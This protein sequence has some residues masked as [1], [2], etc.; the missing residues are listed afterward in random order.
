MKNTAFTAKYYFYYGYCFTGNA[1]VG[2]AK[3]QGGGNLH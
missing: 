2:G 3:P 1:L